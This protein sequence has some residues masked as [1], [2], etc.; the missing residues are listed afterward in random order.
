[1]E[2]FKLEPT[3]LDTTQNSIEQ[4]PLNEAKI[5]LQTTTFD[6]ESLPVNQ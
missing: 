3:A 4:P 6:C 2:S 1:M 5:P